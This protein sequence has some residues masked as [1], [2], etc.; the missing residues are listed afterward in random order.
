MA[1]FPAVLS[2]SPVCIEQGVCFHCAA[3][4]PCV[5]TPRCFSSLPG[6]KADGQHQ[7]RKLMCVTCWQPLLVHLAPHEL[8]APPPPPLPVGSVYPAPPPLPT[9]LPVPSA[10]A[11]A[12]PPPPPPPSP[13]TLSPTGADAGV[14]ALQH[15]QEQALPLDVLKNAS[16]PCCDSIECGSKHWYCVP[17]CNLFHACSDFIWNTFHESGLSKRQ[18]Q[19]ALT[20]AW[21]AVQ[22]R[23]RSCS[24]PLDLTVP[25]PAAQWG[26]T[27]TRGGAFHRIAEDVKG[28]YRKS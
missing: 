28:F 18:C 19:A 25:C 4:A 9:T 13:P 26:A 11:P 22:A 14:A 2:G 15:W 3:A 20:P 8:H 6:R 24:V 12:P 7:G 17:C 5:R 23:L 1:C 27:M 10:V 16:L 21:A